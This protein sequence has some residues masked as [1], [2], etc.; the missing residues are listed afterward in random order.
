[1]LA[2]TY[3]LRLT[4]SAL[5]TTELDP[6]LIAATMLAGLMWAFAPVPSTT[7]LILSACWVME[8]ASWLLLFRTSDRIWLAVWVMDELSPL[9]VLLNSVR[10]W[11]AVAVMEE[12]VCRN[13]SM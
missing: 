10:S 3:P 13:L 2:D 9:A 4:W 11:L 1:M 8:L 6:L 12:F 5:I 7:R